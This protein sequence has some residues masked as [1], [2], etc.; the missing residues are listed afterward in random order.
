MAAA[1]NVM[2]LRT[3]VLA[4][5]HLLIVY[6]HLLATCTALGAIMASDL[7]LLGRLGDYRARV[8]PP[9]AF[10]A[11]LVG[12]SLVLLCAT[13]GALLWLGVQEQPDY[14]HN[15]KLQAKLILV[16]LLAINALVLHGYTFPRLAHGKRFR[17]WTLS[18]SLGVAVPVALSNCLWLFCAFLGVARRWNDVVPIVEVLGIAAAVFVVTLCVVLLLLATAARDRP[19]GRRR[20]AIDALKVTFARA[21][22]S[23]RRRV[24]QQKQRRRE[25]RHLV[26]KMRSP[27]S[28]SPG[29]M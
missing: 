19:R 13:G 10:V 18:D 29:T 27:A 26:P 28:P 17:L 14:L 15:P 6:L 20:D 24:L 11:H 25:E 2:P 9:N 16:A 3:A 22:G 7:R 12:L 1:G 23:S 8:A 21:P 5:L 4:V